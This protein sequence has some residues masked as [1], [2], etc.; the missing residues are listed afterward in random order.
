MIKHRQICIPIMTKLRGILPLATNGFRCPQDG[1][2]TPQRAHRMYA[3]LF[4]E[5]KGTIK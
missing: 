3:S 2:N 4:I 1:S 5:C